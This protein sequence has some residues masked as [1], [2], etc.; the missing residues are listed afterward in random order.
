[1]HRC[2][3]QPGDRAG[4]VG[5]LAAAI[6]RSRRVRLGAAPR[7]PP[8]RQA[9]SAAERR[10]RN[11]APTSPTPR[12]DA[13]F[14]WEA[15]TLTD[16]EGGGRS[17]RR[18]RSRPSAPSCRKWLSAPRRVPEARRADASSTST[19]RCGRKRPR[20]SSRRSTRRRPPR[21]SSKLN[22]RTASAILGEMDTPRAVSLAA[23]HLRR[24]RRR[25]T[26]A[27]ASNETLHLR[28]APRCA[29]ARASQDFG[30][31]PAMTP[32]GSGLYAY[33]APLPVEAFPAAA[34]GELPLALGRLRAPTS[35]RIRAPRRSATS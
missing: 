32:V 35:S 3:R 10:A 22:S 26:T 27:S 29:A 12:A 25:T 19:R 5:G 15:K 34:P 8:R 23:A 1:M 30:R 17:E 33:R 31:E 20:R 2:D 6:L 9:A 28:A 13:R 18:R 7:T 24:R 16:L 4:L 11:S 21:F 14:A